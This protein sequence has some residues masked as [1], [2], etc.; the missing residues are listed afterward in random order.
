MQSTIIETDQDYME[1]SSESKSKKKGHELYILAGKKRNSKNN[2]S[3]NNCY[4][5]GNINQ[6]NKTHR[7]L[8]KNQIN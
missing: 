6:K 8:Y 7:R 3:I 2:C 4:G 5:K 1:T